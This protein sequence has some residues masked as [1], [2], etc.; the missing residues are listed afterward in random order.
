M[1]PSR[2]RTPQPRRDDQRLE[3]GQWLRTLRLA[4]GLSQNDLAGPYS[5]AYVS[6]LEAGGISPSERAIDT[7]AVRLGV[8]PDALARPPGSW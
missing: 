6:L 1:I 5:R 7:L 8:H 3:F 4:R 2:E